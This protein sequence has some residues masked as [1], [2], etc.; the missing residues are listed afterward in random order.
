MLT[1][2]Q[3]KQGSIKPTHLMYGANMSH[4]QM[5]RYLEDLEENDLVA[6]KE[7]EDKERIHIT[8]KGRQYLQKINEMRAFEE[9]FGL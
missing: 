3:N 8:K 5:Q 2:I 6:R 1:S 4:Q 7:H 9:G